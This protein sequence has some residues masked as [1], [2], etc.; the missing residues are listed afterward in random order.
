MRTTVLNFIASPPLAKLCVPLWKSPSRESTLLY[1]GNVFPSPYS[2]IWPSF[3]AHWPFP[4]LSFSQV[5][6]QTYNTQADIFVWFSLVW[7]QWFF[8]DFHWYDA[9]TNLSGFS[10]QKD[11]NGLPFPTPEDLLNP[12]IKPTSLVSPELAGGV[13]PL[14]PPGK[15][16]S[17]CITAQ[18]YCCVY[19]LMEIAPRTLLQSCSWLFLPGLP[20]LISNCLPPLFF[21][22][23]QSW[24]EQ[25]LDE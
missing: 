9:V 23:P 12:V 10:R 21:G 3:D 22:T 7:C 4:S 17:I 1:S 6:F 20:S 2:Q 11:W 24:E 18:R 16:L 14:V 15:P 8:Y 13:L 19:L 25:M 5:L